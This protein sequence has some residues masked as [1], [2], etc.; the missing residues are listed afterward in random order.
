MS[1]TSRRAGTGG[2][3]PARVYR[4]LR[5]HT[6]ERICDDCLAKETGIARENVNPLTE[7]LGLT[8]DFEK[9]RGACS[10]CKSDTKLVTRSLRVLAET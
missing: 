7:A 2:T 9:R 8:T 1:A 6:P 5:E 10:V 4:L 3:N